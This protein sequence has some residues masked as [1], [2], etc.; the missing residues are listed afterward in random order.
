[1]GDQFNRLLKDAAR[2]QQLVPDAVLV[3]GT[4]SALHA[5]HR[6]STD[7]DHVLLDLDARFETVLDALEREPDFVLNRATPGKL[8]LGELGGIET[9]IR[10]LIR[11]RPL[12]TEVIYLPG[13]MSVVVPTLD[14]AIRIKAFLIVRRN[15]VRDYL[16]LAALADHAGLSQAAAVL[17][18]IDNYYADQAPDDGTV[19]SQLLGQLADPHP[20]DSR[21][22]ARLA[23]YKGLTA[24]W[25][26][27][28][29]VTQACADLAE[30]MLTG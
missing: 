5:G 20:K 24:R 28:R 11:A 29:E 18:H 10:Q 7:H 17:R 21:T 12:E 30:L 15:Q 1:M 14:E 25:Q 26:D 19:A 8:I 6:V 16:D 27:W 22:V 2:L 3:G 4:A 9:G 13:G 23:D